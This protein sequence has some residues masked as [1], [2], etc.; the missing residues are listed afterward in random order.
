MILLKQQ[1]R[2]EGVKMDVNIFA[3]R[4]HETRTELKLTQAELAAKVGITAATVSGYENGKGVKKA[5]LETIDN[6]ANA[7][8][9]SVDW[10]CGKDNGNSHKVTDISTLDYLY[11]WTNA[12]G[13]LNISDLVIDDIKKELSITL[14]GSS[15]LNWFLDRVV[16]LAKVYHAGTI[17]AEMFQTC[18]D[19]LVAETASGSEYMFGNFVTG[20]DYYKALD[21]AMFIINDIG[22]ARSGIAE[23][24]GR[25]FFI[26][27][28]DIEDYTE[29][30][31]IVIAS[32]D[33]VSDNGKHSEENG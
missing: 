17:T 27:E 2:K 6:I 9:V 28:K 18:V 16:D 23:T 19:K 10:L 32:I 26:S 1:Q 5:A 20:E 24:S 25:K 3:K 15:S 14:K 21:A 31:P 33:E 8:N 29:K 13:G 11:S 7:L 22:I 4:L 30:E 12:L